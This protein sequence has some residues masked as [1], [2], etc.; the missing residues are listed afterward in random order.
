MMGIRDVNY[1]IVLD[2]VWNVKV[3]TIWI[4]M[5]VISV[6]Y[7]KILMRVVYFVLTKI[8]V[9]NAREVIVWT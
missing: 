3:V 7:V 8:I 5:M 1:V 9:H 6:N 4:Q 2:F